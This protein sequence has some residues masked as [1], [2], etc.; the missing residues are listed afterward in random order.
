MGLKKVGLDEGVK[1]YNEIMDKKR[2]FNEI[3]DKKRLFNEKKDFL[4]K[5]KTF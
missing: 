2:L 5:K 3:M 1:K 4:M